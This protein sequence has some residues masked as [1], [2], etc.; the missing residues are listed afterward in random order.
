MN[1]DKIT[2]CIWYSTDEGKVAPILDYYQKVFG[3]QFEAGFTVPLGE[4]PSGYAEMCD[5]KIFGKSYMVMNTATLHH[6]LNDAMALMIQC[7]D[8]AEI[9]H[10]WNYFT[11]EG[12]ESQCGWCID[13][14]GLRWQIIP[15]NLGELMSRPNAGEVM[16]SQKKI[17]IAAY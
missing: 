6:P 13:K 1:S 5:V 8:Q 16:I 2:T 17:V 3:K 7:E 12:E 11:S 15:K 9:D 14:F 10:F 4:T